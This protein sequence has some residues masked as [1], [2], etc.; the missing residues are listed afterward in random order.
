MRDGYG[1]NRQARTKFVEPGSGAGQTQ[2]S[3]L[4]YRKVVFE[5]LAM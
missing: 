2:T 3:V 4:T 1:L 5:D